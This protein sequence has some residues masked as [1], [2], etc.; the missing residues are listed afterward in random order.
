MEAPV[1]LPQEEALRVVMRFTKMGRAQPLTE[2]G[3]LVAKVRS[4]GR[5]TRLALHNTERFGLIHLSFEYGR[6]IRVDGN[7]G[8]PSESLFD[9]ESWR[10][11][12]IR[13]EPIAAGA[14]EPAGTLPLDTLL[15]ATL[16]HLE[17][18]RVIHSP[19][20]AV[21]HP[22][23][24]PDLD[25]DA[26]SASAVS[27]AHDATAL[28]ASTVPTVPTLPLSAVMP[29]LAPSAA[30]AQSGPQRA[31]RADSDE[32]TDPQWQLLALAVRQIADQAA[33]ALGPQIS[34]AMLVDALAQASKG[35]AFL[36]EVTVDGT[37]WMRLQS[38]A[39]DSAIS[40]FEAAQAVAML[41]AVLESF[42][43]TRLGAQ[44]VRRLIT[45][46]VAP[47]RH[48]LEQIGLTVATG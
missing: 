16:A 36:R 2:L 29:D 32:L 8:G 4:Q 12:A 9:L 1:R 18:S 33:T 13:V 40:S 23:A 42:Y 30:V 6:L 34:Q 19:P 39:V 7:V 45:A 48:S 11:G 27:G 46:A 10:H 38:G 14:I 37:G 15:D 21:S 20:P 3:N 26:F 25:A 31:V 5:T 44:R 47:L 22:Q 24:L 41:L 28:L 17:R 35:N 43:A